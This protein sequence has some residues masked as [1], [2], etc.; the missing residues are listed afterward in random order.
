MGSKD[1]LYGEVIMNLIDVLD[2]RVITGGGDILVAK[3]FCVMETF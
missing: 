1:V 2:G 3:S